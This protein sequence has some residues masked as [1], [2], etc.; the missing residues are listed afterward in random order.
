MI[1]YSRKLGKTLRN[2]ILKLL[3]FLEKSLQFF[4]ILSIKNCQKP[5]HLPDSEV[6]NYQMKNDLVIW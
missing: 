3:N 4:L 5:G 1:F 2:S 6:K